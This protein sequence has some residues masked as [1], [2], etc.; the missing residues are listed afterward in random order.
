MLL[1]EAIC[2][3]NQMPANIDITYSFWYNSKLKFKYYMVPEILVILVTIISMIL[4]SLNLVAE[5]ENGTIEQI[6]VTPIP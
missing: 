1:R 2:L 4:A 6:N 5:K 3:I